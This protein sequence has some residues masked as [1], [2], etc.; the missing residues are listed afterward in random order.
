MWQVEAIMK[1]GRMRFMRGVRAADQRD[2]NLVVKE[3]AAKDNL[4]PSVKAA[5]IA[6]RDLTV[7][8]FRMIGG[9]S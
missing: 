9:A 2:A 1:L 3:L 5:A 7:E 6:A 8:K 4:P